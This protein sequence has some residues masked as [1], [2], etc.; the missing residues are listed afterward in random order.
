M[1]AGR[2]TMALIAAVLLVG[3]LFVGLGFVL[4]A[5]WSVAAVVLVMWVI[6]FFVRPTTGN[7]RWYRW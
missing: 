5:L 7:A 3:L 6:G 2:L 1:I 4:H